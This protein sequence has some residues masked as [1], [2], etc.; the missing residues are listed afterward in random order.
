VR[1]L[2]RAAAVAERADVQLLVE[3]EPACNGGFA[4]EVAD[5]VRGVGSPAVRALWD[6]GNE[7]YGGREA[8]PAGYAHVKDALAHVH[9]KDAYHR[10]RR[11]AQVRARSGPATAAGRPAAGA[12]GRRVRRAV[13]IETHFVPAG[14]T[15]KT[16]SLM[17]LDALRTAL[18]GSLTRACRRNRLL[19]PNRCYYRRRQTDLERT[20][21]RLKV[22]GVRRPAGDGRAAGTDASDKLRE[23]L[24]AQPTVRMIFAAAPSQN[25]ALYALAAAP[26]IDWSRVT[27]FHMDEYIGLAEDAPQRFGRY[28]REHCS[29]ASGRDGPPDRQREASADEC[30]RYADLLRA[31]RSTSSASGSARTGTS[32]STTRRWPTSP[33]RR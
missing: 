7:V 5:L 8:F 24:A 2:K 3:N 21:D 10:Q 20:V 11:V 30:R 4:A 31:G 19:P 18:E 22:P 28:L 23:L 32:R 6:P 14:S 9:L 27:A 33:T 29:T 16:G 17:T 25:E 1:H 15:Q 26:D 13:P 12:A